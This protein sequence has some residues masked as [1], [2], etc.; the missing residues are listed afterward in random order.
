[1]ASPST[2]VNLYAVSLHF[3]PFLSFS[4]GISCLWG[5]TKVCISAQNSQMS[6]AAFD[7]LK[8][9]LGTTA[10]FEL[11]NQSMIQISATL[12]MDTTNTQIAT[13]VVPVTNIL[14]R[15]TTTVKAETQI[16]KN[17][18]TIQRDKE[19]MAS[20]FRNTDFITELQNTV[21]SITVI[22]CDTLVKDIAFKIK[23]SEFFQACHFIGLAETSNICP[24]AMIMCIKD[25]ED[26]LTVKECDAI[27]YQAKALLANND[28]ALL[29]NAVATLIAVPPSSGC[30]EE[31]LKVIDLLLAN[32]GLSTAAQQVVKLY[33]DILLNNRYSDWVQLVD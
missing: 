29:N 19:V 10:Q 26:R 8:I 17:T 13:L 2:K 25:L 21:K 11:V 18:S 32:S 14:N 7:T 22:S 16:S 12:T 9:E 23:E 4:I 5:Q 28:P 30:K 24:Q 31:A 33:Q 1:M 15:Q 20:F 3:C 27:V 6:T